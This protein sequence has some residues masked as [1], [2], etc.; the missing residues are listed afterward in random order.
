VCYSLLLKK[1]DDRADVEGKLVALSTQ[2]RQPRSQY[3]TESQPLSPA[4]IEIVRTRRL[5]GTLLHSIMPY[6]RF[7]S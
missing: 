1:H 2:T 3:Q 7:R 6:R 5:Q 4:Q